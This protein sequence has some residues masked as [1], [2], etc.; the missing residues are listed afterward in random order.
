MHIGSSIVVGEDELVT[1]PV[2]A[3]GGSVTVLGRVDDDVVAVGGSVRLGPKARVR[4]DVTA[5]GGRVEQEKGAT[6]GGTVNEVRIGPQFN[7]K[8]W[9]VFDGMWFDGWDAIGNGVPAAGHR[10]A[11]QPRAAARAPGRVDCRRVPC[12]GS[13]T[14][15]VA[16]RG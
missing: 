2:V 14:A 11:R 1:D 8:P 15:W 5:V 6:I 9:H 16:T 3:I 13:P 4:G 12:S 10:D 7:F